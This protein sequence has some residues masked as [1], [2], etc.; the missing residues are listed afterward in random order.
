MK[1]MIAGGVGLVAVVLVGAGCSSTPTVSSDKD[2]FGPMQEKAAKIIA[3][4]G[5]AAVGIGESKAISIATDQAKTRART[6]MA[7]TI[8]V[9]I[10]ALKKDFSEQIGEGKN[11]ELNTLFSSAAKQLASVE[12]TGTAATDVKYET[13]SDGLTKAYALVEQNPKIVAQALENAGADN[14]AMY[15]RFRSSQAYKELEDE[16]KKYEEFKKQQGGM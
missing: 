4:G 13:T 15:T 3:N 2:V 1:R 11:A 9:K 6:E 10:D 8:K 7:V 12:L 16:L 14:K 5:L